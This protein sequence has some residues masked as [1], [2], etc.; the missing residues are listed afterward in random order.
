MIEVMLILGVVGVAVYYLSVWWRNRNNEPYHYPPP[1][2]TVTGDNGVTYRRGSYPVQPMH[3]EF[4]L[5]WLL[6]AVME[7]PAWKRTPGLRIEERTPGWAVITAT[8]S[9]GTTRGIIWQGK[10][11][12]LLDRLGLEYEGWLEPK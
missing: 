3:D 5:S 6:A 11:S 2:V 8:S 10:M 1:A 12:S 7:D 4:F 9:D